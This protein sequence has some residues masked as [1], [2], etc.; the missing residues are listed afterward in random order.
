MVDTKK[1]AGDITDL[2]AAA[3]NHLWM[4]NRDWVKTGEEGG[5]DIVVEAKG[6]EVTDLEGKTW[7]DVNG[8][9][10]SVNAGYGRVE[11]AESVRDQCSAFNIFHKV[12]QLSLWLGCPKS[13]LVSH[14]V[15]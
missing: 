13:L 7:I 14:L 8:G 12:Q 11:I 9:Y 6:I 10:N 3:L 1:V 4:H 15:I 2:R 5:P